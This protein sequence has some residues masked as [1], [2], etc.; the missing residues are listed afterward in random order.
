MSEAQLPEENMFYFHV[1]IK[2]CFKVFSC[3]ET[4][5]SLQFFVLATINNI[6]VFLS[7]LCNPE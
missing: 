6:E 5:L 2:S 3:L 1:T 7:S 4:N